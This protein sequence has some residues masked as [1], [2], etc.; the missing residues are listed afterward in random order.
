MNKVGKKLWILHHYIH[1]N[2]NKTRRDWA[3]VDM[4]AKRTLPCASL[5]QGVTEESIPEQTVY[6][7]NVPTLLGE[8]N[9]N[10]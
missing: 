1:Y 5:T 8:S 6:L 3:K 10:W 2:H 9:K 7:Q 4:K